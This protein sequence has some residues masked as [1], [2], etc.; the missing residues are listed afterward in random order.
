MEPINKVS[1]ELVTTASLLPGGSAS[2]YVINSY[3]DDWLGRT[4]ANNPNVQRG[5][6]STEL[7][8]LV[9]EWNE[10]PVDQRGEQ[11][12][13]LGQR[14]YSTSE[15]DIDLTA[16]ETVFKN[17]LINSMFHPKSPASIPLGTLQI[18]QTSAKRT[19]L[20]KR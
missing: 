15:S 5:T 7:S 13:D 9:R 6:I 3:A 11:R 10:T 16:A 1:V 12:L 20:K 19:K 8:Q 4:L 18:F 14:D 2:Q 17:V